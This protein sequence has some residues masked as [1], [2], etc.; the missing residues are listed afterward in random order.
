MAEIRENCFWHG[1][2]KGHCKRKRRAWPTGVFQMAS[3]TPI[4]RN[5]PD[6]FLGVCEAIGQDFGINANIIRVA[7]G[8]CVL[9][10]PLAVVATYAILG[11]AV[12]V[13]RFV[14][15]SVTTIPAVA[16]AKPEAVNDTD[17]LTLAQAA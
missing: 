10:N 4:F 3:N 2:C 9:I 11:V 15:P 6:T 5:R 13:S 14:V 7:F 1:P 16:I 12:A 8:A 17:E